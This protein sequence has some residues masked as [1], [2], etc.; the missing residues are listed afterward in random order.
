V[1]RRVLQR[2]VLRALALHWIVMF[3]GVM[4]IM[5]VGQLPNVLS[6]AAEHELASNLV[7]KVLMLMVIA[8]MPIV[9][10][11]TLLL[12][13]VVTLGHLSHDGELTAMRAA[14]ISPLSLFAI[15][16]SF[17]LPLVGV[18]AAVSHEYAPRAY[19]AAVLARADAARNL[20][21]ARIRPGVFVPLGARGTLFASKVMPDGEMQDVFVSSDHDGKTGVLTAARGRVQSTAGGDEFVL[22]LFDGEIHEGTPGERAFQIMKFRE[23][24]RPIIFPAESRSCVKP[25]TR[26]TADLWRPARGDEVAELNLRFGHLALALALVFVSVPLSMLGPRKGAYTRVPL[27]IGLFAIATFCT[28]GIATWSAR[29]PWMGT[30][31]LW[32]ALTCM[33]TASVLWLCA[34]QGLRLLGRRREA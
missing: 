20:L 18:L 21:S 17:S 11:L 25:D 4:V 8:N 13:V 34:S 15:V 31:V 29:N 23:L 2:Y 24:T 19:C 26:T 3:V 12:A 22:A 7:F 6:R 16:G 32:T 9:I 28:F 10:L 33:I 5:T 14:G 27:A 30:W 1:K